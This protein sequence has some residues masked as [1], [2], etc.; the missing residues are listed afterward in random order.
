MLNPRECWYWL[1]GNCL[2]PT[3]G[4][5]H[6]PLE[7][8]ATETPSESAALPCQSSIP[9][10]KTSVP[11]YFYFNGFCNKGDRCSFLHGSDG[12]A[13]T[14]KPSKAAGASKKALHSENKT[15]GG[16]G[17]GSA[18]TETHPSPSETTSKEAVHVRVQPNDDL[19]KSSTR[20]I[21]QQSASL[22]RYLSESEEAAVIKSDSMTLDKDFM[23]TK[24]FLY[25]DWSY[26]EQ[27]DDHIGPEGR[28]ESSSG[29]D[30]LVDNDNRPETL[31]YNDDPEYLLAINEDYRE[32][33]GHLMG[34][35]SED[36][37]EYVPM[38]H[39]AEPYEFKTY[40]AHDDSDNQDILDVV[41]EHPSSSRGRMLDSILSRKRKLLPMA[42][43]DR[44]MDLRDF[45][46]KRRVVDGHLVIHSSRKR[47]SSQLI[48]Q[49]QERPRGL[50][51][52]QRLRRR[53]ASEFGANYIK[54][55]GNK[56]IVLKRANWRG[57]PRPSKSTMLRQ[58]YEEKGQASRKSEIS[59]ISRE[60]FSRERRCNQI[61]TT[62]T[63]PKSLAE[64]KEEK[65]K[66]EGNGDC[67][68]EMGNSTR[69]LVDFEGPKP[70]S[71]ILKEKRRLD[72]RRD[73]D[74]S[75]MKK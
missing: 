17:A 8:R 19:L 71:E 20:S 15:S 68:G 69:I 3:C 70:L 34:Y 13:P 36:P 52:S 41:R 31:G 6:P 37:I 33:S 22:Q 60:P 30:V 45:L 54:S 10:N 56:G 2:N 46:R 75:K 73:S 65:K 64:I 51:M 67:L 43:D 39:D 48:G 49:I 63:G 12:G 55:H 53:L 35:D 9:V 26:E 32:L 40:N 4:F 14:A 66:A 42:V 23:K 21:P 58:H 38:Y 18:P 47:E 25:T 72:T 28:R 29:F 24:C 27:V 62:F 7:G 74:P 50:V 44:D 16:N 11:C 57:W 1:S 59:V 5:R 61:S